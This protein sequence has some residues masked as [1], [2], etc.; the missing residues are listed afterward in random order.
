[1]KKRLMIAGMAACAAGLTFAQ[2]KPSHIPERATWFAQ[3]DA[4]ALRASKAAELLP[5]LLD[6]NATRQLAAIHAATG[7]NLTNDI[8]TVVL[9]GKGNAQSNAVL[10]LYGR[11]DANRLTTI[12]GMANEFQ[13]RAIGSRNLLSW[14]DN[15]QCNNLC[16][17]DPTHA[18]LSRDADEVIAAVK[19]VDNPAATPNAAL[20]KA[21]A[22]VPNRFLV[23][24]LNNM[25]D[26]VADNQQLV[27]LKGTEALLLELCTKP[28]DGEDKGDLD[29]TVTLNGGDLEQAT[30]L[31][32]VLLGL[33]AILTMQAKDNPTAA[34]LAQQVKIDRQEQI[35]K[36]NI[37]LPQAFLKQF[38][39]NQAA[40]RQTAVP[41]PAF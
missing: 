38:V 37:Q 13:N 11:F 4:K 40:Q 34:A 31:H 27:F 15:G 2:F 22:P 24:Q 36:L 30:Q 8:D 35:I 16:F 26:F 19:Q 21:L 3:L 17:I 1:M 28:I 5:Q 10:A 33:Q 29:G 25:A 6:D 12:L 14:T 23:L 9:F 39:A 41:V 7:I 20:A 18:V 32:Q